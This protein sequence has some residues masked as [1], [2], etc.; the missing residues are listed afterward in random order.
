MHYTKTINTTHTWTVCMHSKVSA[1]QQHFQ[2]NSVITQLLMLF[3]YSNKKKM[4]HFFSA[5]NY[6]KVFF[7]MRS[8]ILT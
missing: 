4:G 8:C 3:S 2:N 6:F 1:T 5:T 7:T